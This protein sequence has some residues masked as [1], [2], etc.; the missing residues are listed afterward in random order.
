MK[1]HLYFLCSFETSHLVQP[2][3]RLGGTASV[4]GGVNVCG[5]WRC[6]RRHRGSAVALF[7]LKAL[8]PLL[9]PIS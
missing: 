9:V 6:C 3:L 4:L 5:H 2:A 7:L 8:P 1:G